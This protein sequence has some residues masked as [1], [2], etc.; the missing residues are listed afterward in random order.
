[1]AA[2][3]ARAEKAVRWDRG[4][5]HGGGRKGFHCEMELRGSFSFGASFCRA[6]AV[7]V[8]APLSCAQGLCCPVC[9]GS[10]RFKTK[11]TQKLDLHQQEDFLWKDLLVVRDSPTGD[12]VTPDSQG[13]HCLCICVQ[14]WS[15]CM[16]GGGTHTDAH[17][18]HGS[19]ESERGCGL[20]PCSLWRLQQQQPY[21][22]LLSVPLSIVGTGCVQLCTRV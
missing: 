7:A 1:M 9:G 14:E 2:P 6:G 12:G 5:L 16:G 11:E 10:T 3:G 4:C 21:S 19:G 15:R 8:R 18:P 13:V 17:G 20:R 22:A